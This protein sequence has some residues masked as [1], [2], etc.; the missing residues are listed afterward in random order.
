MSIYLS[1]SGQNGSPGSPIGKVFCVAMTFERSP[2]L[3]AK[4]R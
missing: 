2:C 1:F 4:M 3:Q